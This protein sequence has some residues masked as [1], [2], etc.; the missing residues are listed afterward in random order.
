MKAFPNKPTFDLGTGKTITHDG[1][2]LRDYFA[3]S[4]MQSLVRIWDRSDGFP[5][6]TDPTSGDANDTELKCLTRLAYMVADAMMEAKY[7]RNE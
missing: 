4:A 6:D 7:E 3:S 2:D 1:M 5:L